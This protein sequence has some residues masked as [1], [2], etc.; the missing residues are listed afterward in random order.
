[1]KLVI[2]QGSI[3]LDTALKVIDFCQKLLLQ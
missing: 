3:K 1:M 2:M